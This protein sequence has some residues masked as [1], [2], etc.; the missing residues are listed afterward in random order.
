VRLLKLRPIMSCRMQPFLG[1]IGSTPSRD[2]PD[3]HNAGD[4]GTFL[5]DA[6]HDYAMTQGLQGCSG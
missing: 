2:M 5:A 3:S 6:P 4:F 1:N